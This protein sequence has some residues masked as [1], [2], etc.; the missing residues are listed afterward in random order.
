MYKRQHPE[1]AKEIEEK[2]K[3]RTAELIMVSKKGK[4]DAA[5]QAASDAAA[6]VASA[7]AE[8]IAEV[9]AEQPAE[10]PKAAPK[11]AAKKPPV[12]VIID[13]DDD[14]EEFTPVK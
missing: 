8:V 14:F 1:Q 2:I 11:S 3:Q 9:K 6:E 4:K 12:N 10:Q 13:A 7:G 5:V